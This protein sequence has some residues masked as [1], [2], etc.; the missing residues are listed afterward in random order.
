MLFIIKQLYLIEKPQHFGKLK[1]RSTIARWVLVEYDGPVVYL[2]NTLIDG[3]NGR[4]KLNPPL[5]R[6]LH[7]FP[8]SDISPTD[9]KL[10]T[11]SLLL[12]LYL[13][14]EL[15]DYGGINPFE[16]IYSSWENT[17][18]E[19]T[20]YTDNLSVEFHS[21]E[22][23][24]NHAQWTFIHEVLFYVNEQERSKRF[25]HA[26]HFI[27]RLGYVYQVIQIWYANPFKNQKAE[28]VYPLYIFDIHARET[29]HY[30]AKDVH[31]AL[32]A[33]DVIS[34]KE[35]SDFFEYINT[36]TYRYTIPK[37]WHH[38]PLGIY[39]LKFRPKDRAT[40]LWFEIEEKNF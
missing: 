11:L 37:G 32:I 13:Y 1:T 9:T 38:Y 29:E 16:G 8:I 35:I 34:G 14:H 26:F 28:L 36:G 10:D 3:T 20:D 30:L 19:L 24:H 15:I 6:I 4:G 21:I 5:A 23:G 25:W 22:S 40:S 31:K 27:K 39:R 2:S 7:N 17:P 18:N 33:L 12:H